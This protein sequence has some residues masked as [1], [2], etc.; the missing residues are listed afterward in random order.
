MVG[1]RIV[2]TTK[3]WNSLPRPYFLAAAGFAIAMLGAASSSAEV[4]VSGDATALR[5]DAVDAQVIQVLSALRSALHIKVIA[6]IA[7]DKA[8]SGSY[9]GSL[10]QVLRNLLEGYNYVVMAHDGQIE[11]VV[12]GRHGD[13]AIAAKP[14]QA[15]PAA[16]RSLTAEWRDRDPHP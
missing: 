1:G 6:G 2:K 10:G 12:L 14:V 16:P 8:V 3:V 11:I 15:P 9:S 4:R 7:P 13:Q 5:V